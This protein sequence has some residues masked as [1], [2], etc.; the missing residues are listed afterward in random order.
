MNRGKNWR[1]LLGT[2][3][4]RLQ[5]LPRCHRP[6]PLLFIPSP[7]SPPEEKKRVRCACDDSELREDAAKQ[8]QRLS[9]ELLNDQSLYLERLDGEVAGSA[10]KRSDTPGYNV[11]SEKKQQKVEVS[12]YPLPGATE[13]VSQR[14]PR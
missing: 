5:N 14:D 12:L 11:A 10:H 3:Y 2:L 1:R 4:D 6:S 9:V 8:F 13:G 7:L